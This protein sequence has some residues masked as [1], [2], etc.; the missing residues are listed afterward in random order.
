MK[1]HRV[2]LEI[3]CPS[4]IAANMAAIAGAHRV[5][6][7]DN[8]HLGGTT[9]PMSWLQLLSISI[10]IQIL[11]RPRGGNFVYTQTEK[12]KILES[13]ERFA[14]TSIAGIVVG[15]MT[16][17]HK[18]DQAF[19][20]EMKK[21]AGTKPLTFHR[22]FD[23][24][25]HLEH[26]LS[27]LMEHGIERVL[28]TGGRKTA[29]DG[30]PMLKK[31]IHLANGKIVIMPGGGVR[32]GNVAALLNET[33]ATEVHSAANVMEGTDAFKLELTNLLQTIHDLNQ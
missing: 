1:P 14:S 24:T 12:H 10:P 7:C 4:I 26:A 13:I 31:L 3:C 30:I 8:L 15:A 19:L 25:D 5:E 33:G 22:A 17:E 32:S 9:P 2:Q 21:A 18:I 11:I 27:I 23:E 6:L 28:T 29:T 20:K 16:T